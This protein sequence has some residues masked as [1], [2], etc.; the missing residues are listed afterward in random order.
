[1]SCFRKIEV[2][3]GVNGKTYIDLHK[4]REYR[5][6]KLRVWFMIDANEKNMCWILCASVSNMF[7]IG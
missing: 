5:L 6:H 2:E 7:H 3:K 1:M 4:L